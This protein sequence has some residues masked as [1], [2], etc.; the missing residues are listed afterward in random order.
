MKIR[1]NKSKKGSFLDVIGVLVGLL[2]VVVLFISL[3]IGFKSTADALDDSK[4]TVTNVAGYNQ[5][6]NIVIDNADKYPVFWDYL[7]VIIA[8][9]LWLGAFISA[10]LLGN[11]PVFLAI[12]ILFSLTS[13]VV[14]LV[15]QFALKDFILNEVMTTYTVNFPI[16][17]WMVSNL[18]TLSIF[19]VISL[20]IA[21]YLKSP[22]QS[23]GGMMG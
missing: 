15:M 20:A 7:I 1:L 21:L 13:L 11:N 10:W 9:F 3:S 22:F 16:V 5:S 23:Q 4:S 17:S 8:F 14:G 18:F 12:Y 19:F 2:L 6:A